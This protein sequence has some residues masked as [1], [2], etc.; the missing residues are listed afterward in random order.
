MLEVKK[1]TSSSFKK[2][3]NNLL[4]TNGIY[5]NQIKY[6]GFRI[7]ITPTVKF[8]QLVT[9]E[10]TSKRF[11][12][13]KSKQFINIQKLKVFIDL[14]IS[15]KLINRGGLMVQNQLKEIGMGYLIY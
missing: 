14:K 3:L 13:L 12:N 10:K 8:P 15:E 1:Q 11:K 5:P 9:I 2:G 6:K 7:S 4:N